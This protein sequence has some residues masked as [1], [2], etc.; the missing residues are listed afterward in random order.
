MENAA[1]ANARRARVA[2]HAL[3]S[4]AHV[5]PRYDDRRRQPGV[6]PPTVSYV[7]PGRVATRYAFGGR[8]D[9]NG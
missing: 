3:V 7:R 9:Q 1:L 6:T 2:Y 5:S 4:V 8:Y